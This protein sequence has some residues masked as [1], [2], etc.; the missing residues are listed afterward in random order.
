MSGDVC[1]DS[2]TQTYRMIGSGKDIW[3]YEDHF[4]YMY[5]PVHGDVML[6]AYCESIE[7]IY[8]WS[9]AGPMIREVLDSNSR[10]AMMAIT[11]GNG[12]AFHRRNNNTSYTANYN[13][14]IFMHRFGCVLQEL[15]IHLRVLFHQI[16][17]HGQI[18]IL[19]LLP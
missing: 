1:Y 7:D 10:H 18:F 3:D 5:Q 9:K 17:L 6:T 11:P 15:E 2:P 19:L 14:T 8:A 4:H 12:A 13:D 16:V